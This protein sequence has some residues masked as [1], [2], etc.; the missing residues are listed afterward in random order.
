MNE[1]ERD[2]AIAL[3]LNSDTGFNGALMQLI[4]ERI[5][6]HNTV[7]L[8]EPTDDH[9]KRLTQTHIKMLELQAFKDKLIELKDKYHV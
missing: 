9:E 4:D 2:K 3:L 7:W 8:S 6:D 5:A 1:E